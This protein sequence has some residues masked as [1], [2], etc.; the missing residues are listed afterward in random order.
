MGISPTLDTS[1]Q[2]KWPTFTGDDL[3]GHDVVEGEIRVGCDTINAGAGRDVV[4]GDTGLLI[5]D[6]AT[7]DGQHEEVY[8]DVMEG[9]IDDFAAM[10]ES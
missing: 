3:T 2:P 5:A 6:S 4:V 1:E 7:L 9:M 8:R 10:L